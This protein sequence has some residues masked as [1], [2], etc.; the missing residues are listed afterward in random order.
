MNSNENSGMLPPAA[1]PH[2][3]IGRS[4]SE[5]FI[6]DAVTR[7]YSNPDFIGDFSKS[8]ALPL[9]RGRHQDLKSI[10]SDTLAALIT[11]KYEGE[12]DEFTIIDCRYPYE[13][14]GG[15]I[16]G[17]KNLFTQKKLFQEFLDK[18]IARPTPLGLA[19]HQGDGPLA[20]SNSTPATTSNVTCASGEPKRHVLIFHCE[21]S[22]ERGP[23]L[24]RFLR[25]KDRAMNTSSYPALH[26][27]EIYLLEG[28]YKAFFEKYKELCEPQEYRPMNAEEFKDEL[29]IYKATSKSEKV[30]LSRGNSIPVYSK[31]V[32]K[33]RLDIS[34]ESPT[35]VLEL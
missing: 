35:P 25:N 32:K 6:M 9:V 3:P 14:E 5:S 7:S 31:V 19:N 13:Y 33:P 16:R 15:H 28:G 1:V 20:R 2:S 34:F 21:F 12:I 4:Y 22:S 23:T 29:R 17:A 8:C 30:T 10:N 24:C 11:G 26:Y 27:P 18:K